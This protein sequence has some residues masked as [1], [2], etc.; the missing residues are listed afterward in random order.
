H[1]R[2]EGGFAKIVRKGTTPATYTWEVTDKSGTVFTYGTG[3]TASD[4][5]ALKDDAGNV[6]M[7]VLREVK[8]LHGN[9]VRYHYTQVEDRGV[10]DAN[11][12][13]GRDLY[14]DYIT[15]TG[16]GSTE[17]KYSVTFIRDRQISGESL[18][19]DKIIDARGGFKQVTADRLRKIEV[20]FD[21]DGVGAD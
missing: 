18:R 17:G 10:D 1:T 5:A 14:P 8:D 19:T 15:W 6:F 21:A 7:W 4:P 12:T 9:F 20:K 16:S 3:G 13:V 11:A 2:V